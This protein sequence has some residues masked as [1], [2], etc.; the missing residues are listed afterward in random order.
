VPELARPVDHAADAA[1]RHLASQR[2]LDES[3]P[4]HQGAAGAVGKERQLRLSATDLGPP[5]WGQNKSCS[6]SYAA[7]INQRQ[8][9]CTLPRFRPSFVSAKEARMSEAIH[10][11]L[12]GITTVAEM[13]AAFRDE[14][15]CRHLLEAMVW[16][17]GRNCPACGYKRSTA[18]AGRDAGGRSR[19]VTV[20]KAYFGGGSKWQV[21][22][23]LG[24]KM[25][26]V[27]QV[28]TCSW[29]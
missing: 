9:A 29:V 17:K 19:P 23:V 11:V 22:F 18:I 4:E 28:R 7:I 14:D 1:F 26:D 5:T 2:D 12:A 8:L 16:A 27:Y 6:K 3:H 13:V 20:P 10:E 15:R 21:Y 24:S 25:E